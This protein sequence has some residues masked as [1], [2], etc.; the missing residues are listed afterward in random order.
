VLIQISRAKMDDLGRP[1]AILGHLPLAAGVRR[2][3]P[4]SFDRP[5]VARP[6]DLE[7]NAPGHWKPRNLILS[8]FHALGTARMGVKP[9][10]PAIDPHQQSHRVP[11]LFVMDGGYIPTALGANPETIMAVATRAAEEVADLLE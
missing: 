1:I 5:V 3:Y 8:A 2:V 9:A 4:P 10:D 7:P 6:E 11:G